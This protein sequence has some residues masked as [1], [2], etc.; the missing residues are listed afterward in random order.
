MSATRDGGADD[1]LPA[2]HRK[3]PRNRFRQRLAVLTAGAVLHNGLPIAGLVG[4]LP[5]VTLDSPAPHRDHA[6]A[7][8]L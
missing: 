4:T 1:A 8:P 5:S 2:R 6:R 3:H 7:P